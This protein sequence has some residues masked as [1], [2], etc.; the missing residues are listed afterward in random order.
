MTYKSPSK[1]PSPSAGR[2]VEASPRAGRRPVLVGIL[3]ITPDSFSDGGD[4][5]RATAEART[6][7][8]VSKAQRLVAEGAAMVDVGGESTRPGAERVRQP[9]EAGRVLPAIERLADAGIPVS[10][11]T[12]YAQTARDALR[13]TDGAAIVNDV[14]GGQADD[15]MLPLLAETGA[16]FV[17]SHWR[18]HSITM[19]SRADYA[20]P[21]TEILDEL[22]GARDR[23]VEA[24]LA[25]E[26]IILD[27]GLGFAK[28]AGDNWAVLR[29]LDRFTGLGHPLLI[30]ASRK[31]F[32]GSLLADDAPVADR[33]LP[34]AI[35]SALCARAGVW[36]LRVHNVAANDIALGVVDAWTN[37]VDE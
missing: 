3:N 32:T 15:G 10:I 13:I 2:G 29:N 35:I 20:D 25:P 4:V 22:A 17:L 18:G 36:G 11:D 19:N 6:D 24:G 7:A 33:D 14:S 30:G 34:T 27:P 23:A 1:P 12:M 9:E 8:A 21:A 5:E 31:R 16:T 26:Q 28:G 37:G